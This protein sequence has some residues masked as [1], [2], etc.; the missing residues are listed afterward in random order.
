MQPLGHCG[1][2]EDIADAVLYL[3]NST[4]TTGTI[5]TVDGGVNASGDGTYHTV[6]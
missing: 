5:I 1:K 4:W 3:A 2:P 6:K